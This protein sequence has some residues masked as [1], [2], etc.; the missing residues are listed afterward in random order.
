M[1]LYGESKRIIWQ[2]TGQLT[3]RSSLLQALMPVLGRWMVFLIV[4]PLL[5]GFWHSVRG[6]DWQHVVIYGVMLLVCAVCFM[7]MVRLC[8]S[9]ICYKLGI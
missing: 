2:A 5:Y 6:G 1:N 4:F 3:E 9:I 7:V 8:W